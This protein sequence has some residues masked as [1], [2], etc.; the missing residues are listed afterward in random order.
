M[1][2]LYG[3]LIVLFTFISMSASTMAADTSCDIGLYTKYI[4]G[5][6]GEAGKNNEPAIQGWCRLTAKNGVYGE[7]WGSQST[8][9][10]GLK[11]TGANEFDLTVGIDKQFDDKW[12]ADVHLAYFDI[13][14]PKML[15]GINGDL[16]NVGGTLRYHVTPNTMVYTNLEGYHGIG[17]IGLAGGWR[18][19]L[20]V[21]TSVGPVVVDGILY[22]NQNFLGHGQFAKVMIES[23]SPIAK[24]AGGEIRP[25]VFIWQPIGEYRQTRDTQIVG[26]IHITF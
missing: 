8:R 5:L 11:E 12:S 3:S 23:K 26:A 6:G 2:K 15:N 19:G 22:H 20:G 14:N 7:F 4:N 10:P 17:D 18:A 13:V 1:K 25:T 16:A 21:R 24:F 9:N